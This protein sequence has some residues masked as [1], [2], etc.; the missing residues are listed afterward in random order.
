[1]FNGRRRASSAR[2]S[3]PSGLMRW[4]RGGEEEKGEG[5]AEKENSGSEADELAEGKEGGDVQWEEAGQL[6]AEE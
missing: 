4:A 3:K 1:M 5:G 6:G 2:R